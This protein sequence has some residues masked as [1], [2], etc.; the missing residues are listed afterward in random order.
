M[1]EPLIIRGGQVVSPLEVERVLLS[2]PGVAEACVVGVPDRFWD[3]IVAA[4]VRLSEPLPAAAA[5][6]TAY[7]RER[8]GPYQVPVRWL[9]AGA[10]PRTGSGALCRATLKAHLTVGSHLDGA[11]WSAEW[12][13]VARPR[14]ALEDIRIPRQE[15]W[16]GTLE[17][18]DYF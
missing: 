18:L 7:C 4:A 15:R 12:P 2:H 1:D 6:L 11:P 13:A 17:D 3:E 10:L 14:P 9:F 8:L 5:D 16:S